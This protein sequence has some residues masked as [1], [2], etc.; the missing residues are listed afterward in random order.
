[1][2]TT[3]VGAGVGEAVRAAFQVAHSAALKTPSPFVSIPVLIVDFK[4]QV[5]YIPLKVLC[6]P[7]VNVD[8]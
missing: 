1:V 8:G 4:E 7:Q 2:P 3:Y 5:G 6:G